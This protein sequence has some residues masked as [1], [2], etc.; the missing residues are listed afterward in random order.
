MD[1][2]AAIST[3]I[4]TVLGGLYKFAWLPLR[5][6]RAKRIERSAR[7]DRMIEDVTA[8]RGQLFPNGGSS[9]FDKLNQLWIKVRLMDQRHELALNALALGMFRSDKDGDWTW[10]NEAVQRQTGRTDDEL[11][12]RG[13]FS[14]VAVEQRESIVREWLRSVDDEREM[15]VV[16]SWQHREADHKPVPVRLRARPLRDESG[17]AIGHIGFI[18][19]LDVAVWPVV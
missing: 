12:G 18:Q 13:W 17:E 4:M 19:P 11:V 7:V 2:L 5:D 1:E 14:S 16:F 6:A 15:D 10:I 9:M 8:I 3:A